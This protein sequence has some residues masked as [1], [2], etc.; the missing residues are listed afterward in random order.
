MFALLLGLIDGILTVLALATGHV[1]RPGAIL[2]IGLS[3]RVALGSSLSGA[4]VYF[5]SEYARQ[6]QRLIHAEKEL[7]LARHGKLATTELGKQIIRETA[8]GMVVSCFFNF[9]GVMIPLC[10][11]VLFPKIQWLAVAIALSVLVILGGL[12]ARL[13]LG[14]PVLWIAALVSAGMVVSVIG[15][16]LDIV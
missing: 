7:N 2:S 8:A 10:F 11:A 1:M 13:V 9:F 5:F 3:V 16:A 4:L 14:R 15:Y 12:L 6:R